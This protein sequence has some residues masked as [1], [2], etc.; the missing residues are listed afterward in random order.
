MKRLS[1]FVSKIM[2]HLKDPMK[3]QFVFIEMKCVIIFMIIKFVVQNNIWSFFKLF[4]TALIIASENGYT[5]IAKIL[6]EQ[7][8]IDINVKNDF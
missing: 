2:C 4:M 7:K 3:P 8:G 5:E 6:G 1:N